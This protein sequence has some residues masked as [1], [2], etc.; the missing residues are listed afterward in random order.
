M[1]RQF[2][3]RGL[4]SALLT[5]A[6]V[7]ASLA[8]LASPLLTQASSDLRM[9]IDVSGSMREN[10]PQNLRVPAL[11]LVSELL[12]SGNQSG[13]WL[14]ADR[15]EPLVAPGAVDD[16]WRAQT[17]ERL[18]RIHSN[19][20]FTDIEA[21]IDAALA[22]WSEPPAAD[23]QR[24][25]ILLT[26]GLVDVPDAAQ[27]ASG[28]DSDAASRRRILE[29][30]IPRLQSLKVKTHVVAL[31]D[32]VDAALV[33]ALTVQTGGW[34]EVANN[35]AA[36]QRAFL[37]MLE[38]SAPPTTVPIEGNRF[39]I[40]SAVREFTLLAFHAPDS[41]VSLI[42]PAGKTITAGRIPLDGKT[43]VT[44][45]NARDYDLVTITSPSTGDW[46]LQGSL[47]PDNRVAV[48]TDLNLAMEPLPNAIPNQAS[49][50]LDV[51][52]TEKGAPIKIQDFLELATAKAV[53]DLSPED[54]E[55][56]VESA[57]MSTT[58][59]TA[60]AP[61][62]AAAI[63]ALSLILPL[64]PASLTYRMEVEAG[65]LEPG[66]YEL[67]VLLESATFQRQLTRGLRVTGTPLTLEYEPQMPAE[68]QTGEARLDIRLKFES[69]LIRPG[70]LFGYLRLKGP[71]GSEAVLEFNALTNGSATYDIPITR[72]GTYRASA[73]LKAETVAGEPLLLEP[74]EET[75]VFDFDDG[76]E[77]EPPAATGEASISWTLLAAVVGGGTAAFALLM[78]LV[79]FITRTPSDKPA[80]KKT[81][82]AKAS[83]KAA[84][85]KKGTELAD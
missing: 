54:G 14:F 84:K 38:Q 77:Q 64:D 33:E 1:P 30:I 71:E 2:R 12:P 9:L 15:P 56:P 34:L 70:S 51:W 28:E 43:Q 61:E 42:T 79:L 40:D 19:G 16:A 72:A 55:P 63:P 53:F 36:L 37:R 46:E 10:D 27:D 65:T 69:N 47:D 29:T 7:V 31:S 62:S 25:L 6:Q 81:K 78:T 67:R 17:R 3:S 45:N 13:V 23:E 85:N 73:R 76:Q 20:N 74:P 60:P 26:D 11:R 75:F 49:F 68:G 22:G 66:T 44:W 18:R 35:A 59:L 5:A 24:H 41:P 39:T 52:P 50:L 4:A 48:L 80:T 57:P 83:K 82:E 58:D 32:Q 8:L 21:A